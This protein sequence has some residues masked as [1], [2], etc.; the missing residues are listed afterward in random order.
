MTG[1]V[2]GERG[3][4]L[5]LSSKLSGDVAGVSA[6]RSGYVNFMPP[7]AHVAVQQ[8]EDDANYVEYDHNKMEINLNA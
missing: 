2:A 3:V 4:Q 1:F 8:E 6:K 7:V 5:S